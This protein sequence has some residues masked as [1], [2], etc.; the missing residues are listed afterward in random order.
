MNGAATPRAPT[1]IDNEDRTVDIPA[2]ARLGA[3]GSSST[4]AC[5]P[6][7]AVTPSMWTAPG[8]AT[9]DH[10]TSPCH[11]QAA[12]CHPPGHCGARVPRSPKHH[13]SKMFCKRYHLPPR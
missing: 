12:T 8:R 3:F 6:H 11:S 2:R 4:A 9:D 13:V 10:G 1:A 5:P 7:I